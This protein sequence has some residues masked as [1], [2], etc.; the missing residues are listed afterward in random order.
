MVCGCCLSRNTHLT[1]SFRKHGRQRVRARVAC[2]LHGW[3]P[4]KSRPYES[5]G[6]RR[7]RDT[8]LHLPWH[9]QQQL[10]G[11]RLLNATRSWSPSRFFVTLTSHTPHHPLHPRPPTQQ[12]PQSCRT[13][14][15]TPN[16][17]SFPPGYTPPG[18]LPLWAANNLSPAVFQFSLGEAISKK[19]LAHAP[20]YV[21]ARYVVDDT[22]EDVVPSVQP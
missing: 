21:M 8:L 9:E 5:A 1:R 3:R 14:L 20:D 6:P 11:L 12:N 19:I 18:Y 7:F 22:S 10:R 2:V 17:V 4:R 16:Y 13:R 15:W